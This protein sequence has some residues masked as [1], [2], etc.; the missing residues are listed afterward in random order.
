MF[1]S[2]KSEEYQEKL[3]AAATIIAKRYKGYV[4]FAYIDTEI[5]DNKKFIEFF[6]MKAWQV[7]GK[8]HINL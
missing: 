7:P 5:E 2:K 1:L 4:H 8:Y 6:G 3:L